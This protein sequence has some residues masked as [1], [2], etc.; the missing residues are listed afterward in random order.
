M[1]FYRRC[2]R[3]IESLRVVFYTGPS[4]PYPHCVSSRISELSH[5]LHGVSCE[6][7]RLV[8]F[9]ISYQIVVNGFDYIDIDGMKGAI[10]GKTKD[11]DEFVSEYLDVDS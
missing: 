4:P 9:F 8:F 7:D 2:P 10:V 3:C 11:V 5:V 6:K 1:P